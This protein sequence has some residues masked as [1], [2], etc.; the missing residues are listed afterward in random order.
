M[1]HNCKMVWVNT[2]MTRC[3]LEGSL[4]NCWNGTYYYY[5]LGRY[6]SVGIATRYRQDSPGIESWWGRGFPHLSIPALVPTQPPI[7]L[8]PGLS[9]G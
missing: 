7:Q 2:V 4:K 1:F 5:Y 6:S 8:V 3:L 9:R